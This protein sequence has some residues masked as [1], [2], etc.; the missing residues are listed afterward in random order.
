MRTGEIVWDWHTRE[1]K[2]IQG[3][4]V[5]SESFLVL[6]GSIRAQNCLTHPLN[7]NRVKF[8]RA[9]CAGNLQFRRMSKLERGKVWRRDI[10]TSLHHKQVKGGEGGVAR[11]N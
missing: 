3:R 5:R 11:A 1:I 6:R 2:L 10:V 7:G 9:N 8:A 4:S